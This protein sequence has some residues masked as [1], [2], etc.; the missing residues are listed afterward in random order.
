RHRRLRARLDAAR[1]YEALARAIE[2]AAGREDSSPGGL[3]ALSEIEEHVET[4]RTEE[5]ERTLDRAEPEW[6]SRLAG[7]IVGTRSSE[8]RRGYLVLNP[9]G[10]PRRAAVLLPDAAADLRPEGPLRAAQLT[11][12]GVYAVVDLP[13]FGFAWVPAETDWQRSAA[14]T[15]G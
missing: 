13:P 9:L 10:I 8:T 5:A 4:R 14:A 15:K 3:P 7:L 12:E 2:S 6:A 11:D 1:M